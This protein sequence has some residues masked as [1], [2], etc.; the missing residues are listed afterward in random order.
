MEGRAD[1]VIEETALGSKPSVKHFVH[2]RVADVETERLVHEQIMRLLKPCMH[3]TYKSNR[4]VGK[5]PI[6]SAS[7]IGALSSIDRE[8]VDSF[9]ASCDGGIVQS[10]IVTNISQLVDMQ[11]LPTQTSESYFYSRDVGSAFINPY[12]FDQGDDVVQMSAQFDCIV[13]S[14]DARPLTV[15]FACNGFPTVYKSVTGEEIYSAFE[16]R[17]KETLKRM[18]VIR[19]LY[20]STSR[21]TVKIQSTRLAGHKIWIRLSCGTFLTFYVVRSVKT[22]RSRSVSKLTIVAIDSLVEMSGIRENPIPDECAI[23]LENIHGEEWQCSMCKNKLH[24]DCLASWKQ[25]NSSC[26]FCRVAF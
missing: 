5:F 2:S 6:H 22:N 11:S 1:V 12:K 17:C 16:E 24:F 4:Q 10:T 15:E 20:Q 18:Q 26:P 14:R 23:C 25:K 21:P 8:R 3:A 19:S 7:F 13:I 9:L